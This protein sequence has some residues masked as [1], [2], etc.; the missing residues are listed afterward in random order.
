MSTYLDLGFD[1]GSL[2][3][4]DPREVLPKANKPSLGTRTKTKIYSRAIVLLSAFAQVGPH[5]GTYSL[6]FMMSMLAVEE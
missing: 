2:R 3:H 1:I 4:G 5:I 6:I